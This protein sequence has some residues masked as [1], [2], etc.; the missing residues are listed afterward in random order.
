AQVREITMIDAEIQKEV[1]APVDISALL[2]RIL[3]GFRMR[4]KDRAGFALQLAERLPADDAS[5][6]RLLQGVD[7]LPD[8]PVRFTATGKCIAVS[9]ARD[10]ETIVV[11]VVDEGPGIPAENMD[12]IFDRFFTY[13]PD[14]PTIQRHT[15]LGLSIA[16]AI[17]EGYGGSVSAAN[18]E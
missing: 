17:V 7:N 9:S 10:G 14:H 13:R 16:K 3:E 18:R 12:R 15:G 6:Y 4:E 2:Q 8:N 5:S 1:R 11:R